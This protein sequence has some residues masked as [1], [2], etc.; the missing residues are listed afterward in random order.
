M[1]G[2]DVWLA[3]SLS[4]REVGHSLVS[5]LV[6]NVLES[7]FELLDYLHKLVQEPTSLRLQGHTLAVFLI[8]RPLA[9]PV[10]CLKTSS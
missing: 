4:F 7:N 5:D 3:Y 10:C 2:A 8:N 1:F 6:Q 9:R